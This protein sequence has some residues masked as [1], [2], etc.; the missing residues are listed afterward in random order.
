MST[1]L[2]FYLLAWSGEDTAFRLD[3]KIVS[4]WIMGLGQSAGT[5]EVS[6]SLLQIR[7]L[8]SKRSL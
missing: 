6:V 8:R 7:C 4:L 3:I 5:G 2:A 1:I